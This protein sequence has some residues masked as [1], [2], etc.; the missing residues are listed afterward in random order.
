MERR[1]QMTISGASNHFYIPRKT[2]DDRVKGHV[3]HGSKLGRNSVLSAVEECFSC[4]P[5]I[6]G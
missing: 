6:H 3:D 2:L 1:G 4:L 5:F